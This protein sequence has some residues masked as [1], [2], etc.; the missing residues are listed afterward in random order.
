M[1]RSP[2]LRSRRARVFRGDDRGSVT[3][4]TAMMIPVLVLVL[5]ACLA[6]I[7]CVALQVRCI[8]AAREAARLAGRGDLGGA[9]AVAAQLAGDAEVDISVGAS[10]V[11]VMVSAQP[12]GGLLPGVRISARSVAAVEGGA[13]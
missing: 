7:A 12:W 2:A 1:S 4:E 11:R 5:G 9:R 10:Q 6:G 8:D 13:G 3:V